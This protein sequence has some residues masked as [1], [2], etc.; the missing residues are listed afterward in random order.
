MI[1]IE[2]SSINDLNGTQDHR[3][4]EGGRCSNDESGLEYIKMVLGSDIL[5]AAWNWVSLIVYPKTMV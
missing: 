4:G 1:D 5:L 2:V 3:V